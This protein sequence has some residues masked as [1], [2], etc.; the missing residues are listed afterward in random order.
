MPSF[1]DRFLSW[2][3]R[4]GSSVGSPASSATVGPVGCKITEAL[5]EWIAGLETGGKGYYERFLARPSWPGVDSGVTIGVGYDLGYNDRERIAIDWKERT[6]P[7][8]LLALQSVAGIHGVKARQAALGIRDRVKISWE[9]AVLVFRS[10]TIPRFWYLTTVAFPGV[11]KCEPEIQA[12]LLSLV[13]NR[14]SSMD[15]DRRMEMRQIHSLVAQGKL[16][17]IPEQIRHMKRLWV[18]TSVAHGLNNRREEE[19]KMVERGLSKDRFT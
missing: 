9:D 1:L 11:E 15:G 18:G 2:F 4:G 7:E 13:F 5:Y 17:G 16:S 14:G 10:K 8:E 3:S 12:A 6:A 19:A